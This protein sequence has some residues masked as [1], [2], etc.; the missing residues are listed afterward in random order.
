MINISF[1]TISVGNTMSARPP[2]AIAELVVTLPS[3]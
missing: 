1:P 2:T 3:R